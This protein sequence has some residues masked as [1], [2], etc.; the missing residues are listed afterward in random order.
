MSSFEGRGVSDEKS[1]QP[2]M[3]RP[4]YESTR[5]GDVVTLEPADD[6]DGRGPAS[7]HP[8]KGEEDRTSP[9]HSHRGHSKRGHSRNLSEH[10]FDAA[11][12]S[13]STPVP[14]PG[15]FE[16]PQPSHASP[17]VGQKHRRGLS[18]DVSIPTEAHRRINSIGNSAAVQRRP[19][20]QERQHQR[21]DSAGLDIL[22]AAV[23]ASQEELA[24]AAGARAGRPTWDAS[25]S[26][27][28]RSPVEMISYDHSTGAPP[29]PP[30]PQPKGHPR[31][32]SG[33]PPAAYYAP[34]GYP[35]PPPT[36]YGP[37]GFPRTVPGPPPPGGYPVQYARGAE[38]FSKPAPQAPLQQASVEPSESE[39]P[40]KGQ[41]RPSTTTDKGTTMTPPAP[42]P[43]SHWRGN[44]LGGSTQVVPPYVTSSMGPGGRPPSSAAEPGQMMDSYH[45]RKTSSI[46]SW[47]PPS[48][49]FAGIAG[50]YDGH[51]HHRSTSS[52]VSFLG[53]DVGAFSD[54]PDA[55]FLKNLQASNAAPP[56]PVFASSQPP[57]MADQDT[58]AGESSLSDEG[59]SKLAPGGTSKRVRRKCNI[60]GCQNRVVQ[61]GLCIAHGAKRK[62]CKHPGCTKNVKK[63]GLCSTHGPARKR[64]EAE[65]CTKVAVQGGRCIAHGAKKKLCSMDGCTKQ[66]ILGGM[67]KKHHDLSQKLQPPPGEEINADDAQ[68]RPV[69]SSAGARKPTHTRGLSLFQEISP[70]VVGNILSDDTGTAQ[71][72]AAGHRHRST[73]SRDFASLYDGE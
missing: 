63:A 24:S 29:P 50:D 31:Y 32:P 14:G 60:S 56:A 11:K 28:R 57:A 55:A 62:Q 61:G 70:E 27:A 53:F 67:C 44:S 35:Y 7:E 13:F 66:A 65:G 58:Q 8:L 42:V 69:K 9:S 3:A 18:S 36:Y 12:I 71:P 52:S 5:D 23:D 4:Q 39:G 45:H 40:E 30:P 49:L 15:E 10:F 34:P 37:P 47:A 19:F 21:V 54:G 48:S 25:R 43:P 38:A 16:E 72:P 17:S 68:C 6:G 51:G 22:T 33:P 59:N 26:G 2:A 46:S 64:C 1:R 41:P 73:F 20:I